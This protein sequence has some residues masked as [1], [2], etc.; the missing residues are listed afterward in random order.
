MR[1]VCVFVTRDETLAE[2]AVQAAWSIA[3]RK[4]GSVRQPERLRPWLVSIAVNQAKDLLRSRR[5]RSQAEL[6][7]HAR[8]VLAGIDPATGIDSLD[9]L[10]AMDR[11]APEERGLIAMRYVVGFDATELGA[12]IG[13]SSSGTRARLARIL[14]RLRQELS[15]G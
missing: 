14:T 9:L 4:L 3:W 2:E 11:L 13:L 15:H 8:G 1:R 10:A 7:A 6:T 12:A 5:R